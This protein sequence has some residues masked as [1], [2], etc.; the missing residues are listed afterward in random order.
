MVNEI[1]SVVQE[2][3]ADRSQYMYG[4]ALVKLSCLTGMLRQENSWKTIRNTFSST[5][6]ITL[7]KYSGHPCDD[8]RAG[9]R[10]DVALDPAA[11]AAHRGATLTT[12][13][14]DAA[15]HQPGQWKK[16]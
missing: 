4:I 12:P 10:G 3:L 13:R 5:R 8:R 9:S 11:G 15:T 2:K 1:P 6:F 14:T 7:Y 16:Y